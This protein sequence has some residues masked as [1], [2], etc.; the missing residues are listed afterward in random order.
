M[1]GL[2]QEYQGRMTFEVVRYDE[3]DSPQR[4]KDYG[5]DKHG[6]VI[7]DKDQ[8]EP[9]W[10]ESGHKQTR[11]GVEAQIKKLLGS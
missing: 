7:V 4:I 2:A 3:G 9:V 10:V 5:I 8:K 1:H 11:E 6:M